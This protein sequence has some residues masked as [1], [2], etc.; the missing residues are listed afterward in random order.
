MN[1]IVWLTFPP[2]VYY[3]LFLPTPTHPIS[4]HLIHKS[5]DSITSV[6]VL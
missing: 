6:I 1:D 4:T 2:T 5:Y 3:I